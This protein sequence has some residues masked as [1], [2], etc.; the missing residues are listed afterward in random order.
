VT[1]IDLDRAAESDQAAGRRPPPWRYRHAG[2]LLTVALMITLGGAAPSAA[3]IWR[4]LGELGP[5]DTTEV[6]VQLTGDHLYTVSSSGRH[7]ALTAWDLDPPRQ[8]WTSEVPLGAGYDATRGLFGSVTVRQAGDVVL[9]SEGVTTTAL[10]ARLGSVRWTAPVAVT[11]LG[12]GRAGVVVERVFRPGTEYD[13]DSGDPGPL[14]FSSTG[15]PH[16]EAPI[17]TEV[18]GLD[19]RTGETM[20]T[21]A[22]GGSVTVDPARGDPP[23]VLITASDQLLRLDGA[24]GEVLARAGLPELD[25]A[26]PA[27]GS[28]AGGVALVGYQNPSRLVAYDQRTLRRL[29][30]QDRPDAEGEI[31]TCRD[32]ICAGPR[33][34]LRVLDPATGAVAWP[35]LAETDLAARA[36]A[37]LET[38]ADT[39]VPLRL[40]D[41][42]TGRTL[43]DLAGWDE[44]LPGDPDGAL[45]LRRE[46]EDGQSFAAVLPG[47][48]EL[49]LLGTAAV[50]SAEC[51]ADEHHLV[52][53]DGTGL[54]VWA[55]R[56]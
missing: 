41:P 50:N 10:D 4:H 30:Q 21:A 8:L 1:V 12:S 23:A 56:I 16:N 15:V 43:V 42:L 36:G 34:E 48:A 49:R 2:L 26:G 20:W 3:V 14:Y 44:A 31:P 32:V 54:S 45:V 28:V 25:G 13:Q 52:C 24:T 5:V 7:R 33:S 55:Y 9:V 46:A 19:L 17:R 35:V 38:R 51:S 27:T 22:P 47:H 39:D 18:R 11:L 37:V 40:A 29:W 6:P 53:R